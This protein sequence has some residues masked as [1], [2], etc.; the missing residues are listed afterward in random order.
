MTAKS[1]WDE[2][3][4]ASSGL[5]SWARCHKWRN[6]GQ[7]R[8]LWSRYIRGQIWEASVVHEGW[9]DMITWRQIFDELCSTMENSG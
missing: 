5:E 3:R 2:D 8:V 4:R 6:I 9:G 7:R 1:A